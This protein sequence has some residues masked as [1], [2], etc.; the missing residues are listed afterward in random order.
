MFALSPVPYL[1]FGADGHP[2]A[3]NAAFREMFASEP[4][5]EYDVL[6]DETS[7]RLGFAASFERAVAGKAVQMPAAWYDPRELNLVSRPDARPVAIECSFVPLCDRDG[8]VAYVA[9]SYRDVTADLEARERAENS[10]QQLR[11][12]LEAADVGTWEW[13]IVENHV[14]WSP[15]LERIFF[16]AHGTFEG[17]YEAWLALVHPDDRARMHATVARMLET[18]EPYAAEYRSLR[19]EG[20]TAWQSARGFVISQEAVSPRSSAGSSST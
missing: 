11:S 10:E 19:P 15:N 16:L 8:G 7:A 12:M 17:T 9:A 20:G 13:N 3:S 2:I 14:K 4:P 18:L 6:R 1:L 5:P